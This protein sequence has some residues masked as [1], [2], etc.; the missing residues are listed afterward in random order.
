METGLT[1]KMTRKEQAAV[2]QEQNDGQNSP[3]KRPIIPTGRRPGGRQCNKSR[4]MSFYTMEKSSPNKSHD[5]G[6]NRVRETESENSSTTPG[7][8]EPSPK[9]LI[10]KKTPPA[11]TSTSA[12]TI[13]TRR[14]VRQRQSTL[15]K[16]LVTFLRSTRSKKLKAINNQ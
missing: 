14:S 15:A 5:K 6:H 1:K 4:G 11:T 12:Y 3:T 9:R 7:I 2:N 8:S 13:P 16:A 10:Q